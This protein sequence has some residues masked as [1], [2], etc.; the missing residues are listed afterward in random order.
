MR[1]RSSVVSYGRLSSPKSGGAKH[2]IEKFLVAVFLVCVVQFVWLSAT[3][4]QK[5]R[6]RSALLLSVPHR[7]IIESSIVRKRLASLQ[8]SEM[9]AEARRKKKKERWDPGMGLKDGRKPLRVTL[10]VFVASL[11]KSGTTSIW[12]YFQCGGWR[13]SHQWTRID[14]E[15][16]LPGDQTEENGDLGSPKNRTASLIGKCVWDNIRLDRPPF[17]GCGGDPIYTDTGYARFKP[18]PNATAGT[19]MCYYPSVF[20]LE[21]IRKHYPNATIVLVIR[22]P[23]SWAESIMN[24]GNGTLL[25]RWDNCHF[26][27]LPSPPSLATR[28]QLEAFYNWHNYNVRSFAR[29]SGMR[30]IEVSLEAPDAGRKLQESIGLPSACW[31]KCTPLSKFCQRINATMPQST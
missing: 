24:W 15:E 21:N 3:L 26:D 14:D 8:Y 31:G 28:A 17:E 4:L 7:P 27:N 16:D 9:A 6:E 29:R 1:V 11:P 5:Q 18:I 19:P 23:E 20:A 22:K 2:R 30:M 13:A 25:F 12:Q 10:P